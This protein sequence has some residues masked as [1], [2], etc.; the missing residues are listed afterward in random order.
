MYPSKYLENGTSFSDEISKFLNSV[1]NIAFSEVATRRV[2]L[3]KLFLE[4]SQTSQENT[5]A[6]VSF[7]V[8]SLKRDSGTGVVAWSLRNF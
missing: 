2:L 8:K 7:W 6:R 5:N 4:I 1:S 3:K